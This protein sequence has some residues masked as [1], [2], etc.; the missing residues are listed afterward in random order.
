MLFFYADPF[1]ETVID[2][3]TTIQEFFQINFKKEGDMPAL[4]LANTQEEKLDFL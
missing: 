2:G 4:M 3:V 1:E